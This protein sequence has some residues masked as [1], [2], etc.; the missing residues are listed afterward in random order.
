MPSGNNQCLNT[1]KD[2]DSKEIAP[3]GPALNVLC[4]PLFSKRGKVSKKGEK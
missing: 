1:Q 2:A 3:A 4:A